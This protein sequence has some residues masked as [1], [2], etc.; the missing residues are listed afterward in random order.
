MFRSLNPG[1]Q[2]LRGIIGKDRNGL[3]AENLAGIDR[4]VDLVHGA[5]GLRLGRSQ[6]LLPRFQSRKFRQQRRVNVDNLPGKRAE[7]RLLD[8]PH[9][10]S[11]NNQ[12]DVRSHQQSNDILFDFRLKSGSESAWAD[13]Q[14]G[15]LKIVG[16]AQDAGIFHIGDDDPHFRVQTSVDDLFHDRT[17]IRP[18]S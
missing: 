18:L 10:A 1:M 4:C 9:E 15:D 2:T 12:F 16:K 6:S 7:Q 13:V 11:Q 3:A 8:D 17:E 5:T 14:T